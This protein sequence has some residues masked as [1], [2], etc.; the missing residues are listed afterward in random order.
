[1]MD[2]KKKLLKDRINKTNN[3]ALAKELI[4]AIEAG[5][6]ALMELLLGTTEPE[7]YSAHGS[8]KEGEHSHCGGLKKD[9]F[10]EKRLCKCLYYKNGKYHD[11]EECRKCDFPHAYRY[12]IIGD[13]FIADYEVPAFYYGD[14]IGEIDMVISNGTAQYATEVKPFKGNSETL[15]RMIAEI[16]TY[17][18]GYPV[19]KY[20]KAIAFFEGTKQAEEFENPAP[21]ITELLQKAGIAVFC[22]KEE[23]GKEYRICRL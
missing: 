17:T 3:V 14:G 2:A 5:E 11:P 23:A 15:L 16:M 13:Y 18:I 4:H 20:E 1:M 10:T 6:D 9:A 22:F 21:E 7:L 8:Y 12:G 19:G